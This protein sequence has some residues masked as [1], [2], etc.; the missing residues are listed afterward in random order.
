[1]SEPAS[2]L[3]LPTAPASVEEE[4]REYLLAEQRRHWEQGRRVPVETWSARVPPLP[5]ETILQLI[6]QEIV[7]RE[8]IGEAP[9][10]AEYLLRFPPLADE[11]T[12]QFEVDQA[13]G[14]GA[15]LSSPTLPEP[16]SAAPVHA[17][18]G[19]PSLPG[20]ALLGV[21]GRGGMGVVY[22]ARQVRPERLVA[23]K[24]I[25]VGVHAGPQELTRFRQEAEAIAR[26]RHPQIVQIH[27]VGDHAGSPYF[28]LEYIAGGSLA[29]QLSGTPLAA[30]EA[31]RLLETLAE[32]IAYS[33]GHGIV[34][35]DLTPGNIL[36][37]PLPPETANAGTGCRLRGQV[38]LPKI[39]DFGLAKMTTEDGSVTQSGA[40]MGTPSY[41][42]PEQAAGQS[43]TVGPA[44]D[45]Y[46]LGAILYEC[47]TGRP[48][49]KA[50]TPL[51][52]ML[53]VMTDDPV[54]P[55]RLQPR[56]PRDLVTICLKCLQKESRKRYGTATELAQDLRRFLEDKPITARP[57]G[58]P[59]RTWRWCRRNPA[60]ASLGTLAL[61]ALIGGFLGMS[62]LWSRE[63]L[64][65]S[66]ADH[67]RTLAET[68]A[69]EIRAG[70]ERLQAANAHFENGRMWFQI[71]MYKNAR[72]EFSQ[73][74]A[75]RPDHS[76][77]WLDRGALHAQICLWD[78]ARADL[79]RAL[80]LQAPT[81]SHPWNWQA[82]LYL[83]HDDLAAQRR[84][85][86]TMLARFG[87]ARDP[88]L[89]SD[90]VRTC[91]FCTPPLEEQAVLDELGRVAAA[92][93]PYSPWNAYLQGLLDLQAG[94]YEQAAASFQ[95]SL[96]Q[97]RSWNGRSP[98]HAFLAVTYHHLKQPEQARRALALADETLDHWLRERAH[99]TDG[100]LPVH[101]RDWIEFESMCRRAHLLIDGEKLLLEPR[102]GALRARAYSILGDPQRALK[103]LDAVIALRP[104]D[105]QLRME[106]YHFNR[107]H[108]ATRAGLDFTLALTLGLDDPAF[109]RTALYSAAEKQSWSLAALAADRLHRL[110][111]ADTAVLQECAEVFYRGGQYQQAAIWYRRAVER[112]PAAAWLWARLGDCQFRLSQPEQAILAF[113]QATQL[114]PANAGYHDALGHGYG[115]T[116]NHAAAVPEF[117]CASQLAPHSALYLRN[118]ALARLAQ[119]DVAAFQQTAADLVGRFRQTTDPNEA[120]DVLYTV[121]PVR[122]ALPDWTHLVA[123]ARLAARSRSDGDRLLG[124]T[125]YRAGAFA[126][127]ANHLESHVARTPQPRAWDWL[128]LALIH[129]Q[130]GHQQRA[131]EALAQARGWCTAAQRPADRAKSG[132]TW[133]GWHE[134]LEIRFLELEATRALAKPAP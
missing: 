79:S 124:A 31:A 7:L 46:S 102:L 30:R 74:L 65:R 20:Y 26:L 106:R 44:A 131:E 21:L 72:T 133:L 54:S 105:A 83:A 33:H 56:L 17:T 81:V 12:L 93:R 125:L 107:K 38:Y 10:L 40:V 28:A 121:L 6:C 34:H 73:A 23:L 98:A 122:E 108:D 60:S 132:P 129:Q 118:L 96:Q 13:L 95:Q 39:T 43:R 11:L 130:L 123:L 51:D 87:T 116:E 67:A 86:Q 90:T 61:A 103:E 113:Q 9:A 22:Q 66:D 64:A 126:Q 114:E 47:L 112:Q 41:M 24:M 117:L 19:L 49:F 97:D 8:E 99:T 75:I 115:E 63:R 29:Q 110:R 50:E 58:W 37:E 89:A 88:I 59:E 77:A 18:P 35:R 76:A 80:E 109:L 55:K 3:P 53:Q 101:W 104:R 82:V 100:F 57:V 14:S 15:L 134:R 119:G 16:S 27:E 2:T 5:A 78:E 70:M 71:G 92:A 48:P 128:F 94:R 4:T 45:V 62:W 25:L 127:A 111:E 32:T 68:H 52:T 36:L 69:N 84:T 91:A 120:A 1:M 42:A 85:A